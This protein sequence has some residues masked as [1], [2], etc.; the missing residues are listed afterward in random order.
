MIYQSLFFLR[1]AVAVIFI[2]HAIPK[3][4]DPKAMAMGMGWSRGQALGLGIVEFISALG[5]LGGVG[6]RFSA[7]LLMTVMIGAMYH[8]MF[9]WHVP[10]MAR[11]KTG[12][13]LDFLILLSLFTIYLRY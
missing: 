5:I 8:K 9:K 1:F 12:W 11:D 3:L 13:E 10:F 4:K 7:F 2:Y 6:V